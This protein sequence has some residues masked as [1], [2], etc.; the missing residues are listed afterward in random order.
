[1]TSSNLERFAGAYIAYTYR[2]AF[3]A[4][5]IGHLIFVIVIVIVVAVRVWTLV[6]STL[7]IE[8]VVKRREQC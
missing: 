6:I 1:M 5:L 2:K 7:L 8:L 3:L 4:L